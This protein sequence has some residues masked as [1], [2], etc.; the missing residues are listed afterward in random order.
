MSDTPPP[1]YPDAQA[2]TAKPAAPE[3]PASFQVGD[4]T[5]PEPFVNTAQ[6]KLHL[7]LLD[8]FYN[9][10]WTVEQGTRLNVPWIEP[11]KADQRWAWFVT[12]AVER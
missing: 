11:L 2:T 3:I 10:R 5:L 12:L 4:K 9:L 1:S 7:S 8:A 6:L